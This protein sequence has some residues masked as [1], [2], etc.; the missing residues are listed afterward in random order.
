[1][2][3][4]AFNLEMNRTFI[5][6]N[7]YLLSFLPGFSQNT[8]CRVADSSE[9]FGSANYFVCYGNI[10]DIKVSAESIQSPV[11]YW[12]ED[13]DL[14]SLVFVGNVFQL[15]VTES[16]DFYVAVEG[17]G[18]CKSK[19]ERAKK[20]TVN[21]IDLPVE[22]VL[23]GGTSYFS[24]QGVGLT[25]KAK[26]D[27]SQSPLDFDLVFLNSFEQEIHVGENLQISSYLSRG[28]YYYSVLS[29][30]K[31]TGCTSKKIN[32]SVIVEDPN[33]KLENC[34]SASSFTIPNL[35]C[36]GCNVT[37]PGLAIDADLATFSQVSTVRN[38]FNGYIGQNLL[39][40]NLG[41][42]GDTVKIFLSFEGKKEA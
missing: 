22:P 10:E 30:S 8:D 18:V 27:N 33:I 11:F 15:K 12:Y 42:Q 7:I 38:T 9:I 39:F 31:K 2:F 34:S 13:K 35:N 40:P 5:L 29:R 25:V 41:Y 37:N 14:S 28:T 3:F 1:M 19:A 17:V 4:K 36:P 6:F 23:P 24:A 16:K 21:V 32:F 20:I 26:L